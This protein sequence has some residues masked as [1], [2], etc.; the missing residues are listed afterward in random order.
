[1]S[2]DLR[3]STLITCEGISC[4]HKYWAESC[5]LFPVLFIVIPRLVELDAVGDDAV[6]EPML[7][8]DAAAPATGQF[9]PQRL[10]LADAREWL[11]EDCCHQIND[12]ER[13][14]AVR[15]NPVPQIFSK[16]A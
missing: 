13:G 8:S 9:E 5:S 1:M 2:Q 11:S 12:A 10:R 16:L 15:L 6:D 3:L 7:L 14:F 4:L